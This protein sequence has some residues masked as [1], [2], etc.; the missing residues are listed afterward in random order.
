[1]TN[2]MK[3]V[4]KQVN[5]VSA[6]EDALEGA[7][8][9]TEKASSNAAPDPEVAAIAQR[10]QFSPS[11]KRRILAAADRCSE[12][13]E[14]GALLRREGIYS[15]QL[16]TWRKQ[17]AALGVAGLDARK[18]GRKADPAIAQTHQSAKLTREIER[19]R[20]QLAQAQLII[21]VQKKVSCLL[22]L[23]T[24]DEASGESA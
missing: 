2:R 11:T 15:S 6:L 23:Q 1:M 18:R 8:R 5:E 12:P 3:V 19:L 20:R 24:P 4:P 22:A 7:R 16:S 14:I 21:E 10:R 17:R 9:A 13:G